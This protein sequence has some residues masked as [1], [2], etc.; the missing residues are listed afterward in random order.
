M[1][2]SDCPVP[3]TSLDKEIAR[4]ALLHARDQMTAGAALEE[5]AT[6]ACQG[7]WAEWHGWV[8]AVL[9]GRETALWVITSP[10]EVAEVNGRVHGERA[11]TEALRRAETARTESDAKFWREVASLL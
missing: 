11:K 2:G 10:E 7:A 5:A 4:L 8:C 9:S 3:T 1:A 6:V